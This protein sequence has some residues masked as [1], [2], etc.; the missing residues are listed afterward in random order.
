MPKDPSRH[1]LAVIERRERSN[2]LSTA[3]GWCVEHGVGADRAIAQ[4]VIPLSR[5]T[6]LIRRL[7]EE[8]ER[9]KIQQLSKS[10]AE[11]ETL[12]ARHGLDRRKVLRMMTICNISWCL[13]RLLDSNPSRS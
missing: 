2:A 1:Q 12:L 9:K 4:N 10:D 7:K 5:R 11:K 3:V 6:S 13:S 8:R